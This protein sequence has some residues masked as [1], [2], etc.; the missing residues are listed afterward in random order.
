MSGVF[1][2]YGINAL[3]LT[4]LGVEDVDQVAAAIA[5]AGGTVHEET[6]TTLGS[7][8]FV[9]CSDPDGTRVELMKL[10]SPPAPVQGG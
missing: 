10:P 6:R 5:A 8:D 9:Y 2:H 4:H 7:L 1:S 3:G